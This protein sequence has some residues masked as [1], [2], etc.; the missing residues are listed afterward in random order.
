MIQLANG[1][2]MS[3]MKRR[4]LVREKENK[5]SDEGGRAL[6]FWFLIKKKGESYGKE[7]K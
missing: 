6:Y 4:R 5:G 7:E 2:W 1:D 3:A